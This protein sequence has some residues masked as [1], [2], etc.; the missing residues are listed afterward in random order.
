M[1][2]SFQVARNW[3]SRAGPGKNVDRQARL[4]ETGSTGKLQSQVKTA[5]YV[6]VCCER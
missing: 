6:R 4:D 2:I 1:A 3:P 5:E